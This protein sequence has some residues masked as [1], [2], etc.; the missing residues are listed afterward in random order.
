MPA[1][2]SPW[3]CAIV[4]RDGSLC[5]RRHRLYPQPEWRRAIH[6]AS[7]S[8]FRG[9][10]RPPCRGQRPWRRSR[11]LVIQIFGAARVFCPVLELSGKRP[12]NF[13]A[14][15]AHCAKAASTL[16]AS[17]GARPRIIRTTMMAFWSFSFIRDIRV[18]I[19]SDCATTAPD[20]GCHQDY[21]ECRDRHSPH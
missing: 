16:A 7:F 14:V 12:G 19:G 11:L 21:S 17:N 9:S 2:G 3:I 20:S 4:E 8:P 1:P 15:S 13:R 18:A 5:G 10:R 6:P